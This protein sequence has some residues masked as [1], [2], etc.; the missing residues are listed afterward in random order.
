MSQIL[1]L[2]R[3]CTR[4]CLLL[5]VIHYMWHLVL[6]KNNNTELHWTKY[7]WNLGIFCLFMWHLTSPLKTQNVSIVVWYLLMCHGDVCLMSHRNFWLLADMACKIQYVPFGVCLL[8]F[9]QDRVFNAHVLFLEHISNILPQLCT[10][11][12]GHIW[13]MCPIWLE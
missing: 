12:I 10:S 2:L 7:S 11:N 5:K 6:K 13:H 1:F 4:N 8:H 9:L 3:P